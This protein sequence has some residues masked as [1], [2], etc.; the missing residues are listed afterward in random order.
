MIRASAKGDD[1]T[2]HIALGLSRENVNRLVAGQP[3]RVT[4][5]SVN[6]PAISTIIVFFGENEAVMA[7]DMREA[8][9]IGPET[10]VQD[11]L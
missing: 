7:E 3:I 1:G 8:G 9:L 5:A 10:L 2:T 6:C 4:G 11:T